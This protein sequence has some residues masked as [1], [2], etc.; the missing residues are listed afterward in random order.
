MDISFPWI[1]GYICE[2]TLGNASPQDY[3]KQ[4]VGNK[5]TC[6]AAPHAFLC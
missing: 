1:P 5:L 4:S 3:Q 6:L 2:H